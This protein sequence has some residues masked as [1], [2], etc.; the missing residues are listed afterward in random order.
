MSSQN[1][2]AQRSGAVCNRVQ[3][4]H[5]FLRP[6]DGL[7]SRCCAYSVQLSEGLPD[8]SGVGKIRRGVAC[9]YLESLQVA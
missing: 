5:P 1:L 4:A 8:L 6:E 2:L 9:L 7:S 3:K